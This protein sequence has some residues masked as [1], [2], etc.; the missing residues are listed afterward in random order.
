MKLATTAGTVL[1]L[2]STQTNLSHATWTA[3][4]IAGPITSIDLKMYS[5]LRKSV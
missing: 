2:K 4:P 3:S 5:K 1:K